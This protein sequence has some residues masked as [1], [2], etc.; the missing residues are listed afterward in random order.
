MEILEKANEMQRKG[1][2]VIHL[3]VGEPDFNP[4]RCVIDTAK[5]A[6]SSGDTHYTHSLGTMK[7]R[8]GLSAFYKREYGVSVNP[9]RIIVTSGSSPAILLALLATCP[10]GDEVIVSNPGYSCYKNFIHTVGGIPVDVPVSPENGFEYGKEDVTRAI[11]GKTRAIF[12]NSPMNPT[13]TLV[14]DGTFRFLS[15]TGIQI[16]SDEI[17]HGLVYK[18]KARSILEFTDDAIVISGFSKRFA[19]TGFRLG[20]AIVPEHL[21]RPIQILQQNLFICAPSTAQ[22]AG[23][24]ALENADADV[25]KMRAIYNERRIYMIK[26]L[27]EMGFEIAT[28]PLGAFYVFCDA[29]RFTGDSYHFAFDILEKA[30]VGI[31]PGTDFGSRGEG[32]IRLSYANSIERITEGMD[33]I[34]E[35]LSNLPSKR[36]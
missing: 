2:D 21:V 16:I 29:R 25:E 20:Y 9:D 8:E 12:V 34:R 13:G 14:S 18:G 10:Q 11:T 5:E 32:F 24:A 36:K 35:Y 1:I 22:A 7:L 15:D 17:Y 27:T 23:L 26:R 28:E 19:M 3:E 33:R 4:P 31:T 6:L 30:H